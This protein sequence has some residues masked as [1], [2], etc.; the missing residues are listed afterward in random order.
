MDNIEGYIAYLKQEDKLFLST[1]EG[2]DHTRNF[3]TAHAI[4]E[5]ER[6]FLKIKDDGFLSNEITNWFHT[7]HIIDSQFVSDT[8]KNLGEMLG[9]IMKKPNE[10]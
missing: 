3:I 10:D 6:W 9:P 2:K 7:Q 8:I 1:Q 4:N 5:G